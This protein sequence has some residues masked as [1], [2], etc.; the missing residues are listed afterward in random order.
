MND[1]AAKSMLKLVTTLNKHEGFIQL[2][3]LPENLN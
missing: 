3:F 2:N 1:F